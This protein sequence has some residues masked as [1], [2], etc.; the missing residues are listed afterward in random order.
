MPKV[1]DEEAVTAALERSKAPLVGAVRPMANVGS[2]PAVTVS[3]KLSIWFAESMLDPLLSS[4]Q[5]R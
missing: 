5:S 1:T 4:S 3:E 2:P